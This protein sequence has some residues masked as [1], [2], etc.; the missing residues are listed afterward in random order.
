MSTKKELDK[1]KD[2]VEEALEDEFARNSDI[3]LILKIW[4]GQGL[5]FHCEVPVSDLVSPESIRRS[6]QLFQS[7]GLFVPTDPEV[8]KKR[9][10]RELEVRD[11]VKSF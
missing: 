10:I 9:K 6:R 11:W 7:S 4:K 8:I 1:V 2:L 5:R 3:W